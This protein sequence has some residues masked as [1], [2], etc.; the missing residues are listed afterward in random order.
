MVGTEPK[1]EAETTSKPTESEGG[2]FRERIRGR[3]DARTWNEGIG[4]NP[5]EAGSMSYAERYERAAKEIPREE[6]LARL[7][8]LVKDDPKKLKTALKYAIT[9]RMSEE[10]QR[11]LLFDLVREDEKVL[12]VVL[13]FVEKA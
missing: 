10:K 6:K 11:E 5:E 2:S 4:E 9:A 8:E 13:R 1:R 3:C 12:D 7:V